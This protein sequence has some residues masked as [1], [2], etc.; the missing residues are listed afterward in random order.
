MDI[1]DLINP[2][3]VKSAI[4]NDGRGESELSNT[5]WRIPKGKSVIRLLPRLENKV[6]WKTVWSHRNG[7]DRAI[8]TCFRTHG[9]KNCPVCEKSW[10]L[11]NSDIKTEKDLGYS[12]R[13]GVR[14]FFN[15]YIVKDDDNPDVVGQVRVV[16]FGKKIFELISEAYNSE[17]LGVNIFDAVNGYDFEVNKKMTSEYPD[18]TSSRFMVKRGKIGT[19]ETIKPL[20][21]NIDDITQDDSKEDLE[22]KFAFLFDDVA[23]PVSKPY[24]AP[25][26][27]APKANVGVEMSDEPVTEAEDLDAELN[28]LLE[29]E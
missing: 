22:K 16:S 23:P 15:A 21:L 3:E 25:K 18:Y 20:L 12:V 28:E 11:W 9:R 29:D 13:K 14:Y 7:V 24:V 19:W 27:E 26:A 4:E 10:K 1:N 2:S 6:P 17:D 5:F 8:G